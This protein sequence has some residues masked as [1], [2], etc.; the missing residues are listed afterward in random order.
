MVN[1]RLPTAPAARGL[2]GVEH[3]EDVGMLQPRGEPHLPEEPLRA[4]RGGQLGV[5]HLERHRPVVLQV[6]DEIDHG[7]AATPELALEGVAAGEALPQALR[8]LTHPGAPEASTADE[9]GCGK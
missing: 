9:K 4:Q 2:A 8:Q 7:H 5:Q 1:Q 3:G 6:P